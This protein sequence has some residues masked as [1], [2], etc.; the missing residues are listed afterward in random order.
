MKNEY[1]KHN[2][3]MIL[4]FIIGGFSII[5]YI[6]QVYSAF[7]GSEVF[8]TLRDFRSQNN[9][10]SNFT[11]DGGRL[12]E[13]GIFVPI[14]PA[15]TVTS[16]FSIMLLLSGII[17]LLGGVSIWRLT[18]DKELTSTKEKLTSLLLLPEERII[19]LELKKSKGSMTQSQLVRNTG[20]SK[21]KTHRIVNRLASKGIVKKYPY[22]LTNKIV[23][24][25]EV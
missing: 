3:I 20:M 2:I 18:R 13:R 5:L 9:F 23:L 14:N 25:K 24:E 4:C 8:G 16:P 1:R 22:G 15:A 19:L 6:F 10:T 11:P 17:L 21:V 7:W 12:P